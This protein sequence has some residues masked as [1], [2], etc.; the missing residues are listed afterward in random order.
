MKCF[1]LRRTEDETGVS[2]TGIVA[3]GVEFDNGKV[4]LTW[5]ANPMLTSVAVYD[6]M[7]DV[8]LIHGHGG[9][10]RIEIIG[11]GQITPDYCIQTSAR[12]L[13]ITGPDGI[14]RCSQCGKKV[15]AAG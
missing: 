7:D 9:K 3:E 14:T 4:A 5:L 8:I 10:T 12:C 11:G 1:Q 6:R 2:G 15:S 13:G